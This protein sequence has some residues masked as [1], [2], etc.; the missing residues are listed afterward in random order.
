MPVA[1]TVAAA[2][3]V[4]WLYLPHYQDRYDLRVDTLVARR[5]D[6]NQAAVSRFLRKTTPLDAVVLS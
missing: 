2:I 1:V 6:P 5:R 4:R 3:T